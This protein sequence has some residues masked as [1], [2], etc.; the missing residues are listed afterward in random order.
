MF[1]ILGFPRL[2]STLGWP[3]ETEDLKYWYPTSVLITGYDIIF[4][5]VAR[6]I[7]SG[8]EQMNEEPFKYVFIHGLVR[9]S[10]GRKMSKSLGN[11]IDPLDALRFTL[12]TGNSP[13]N[14]M[15]FYTERVESSRNFAN[16]LWNAARFVM[17]NLSID[18]ISLPENP[19]LEDKWILSK[20]NT[21]VQEVTENLEKFEVGVAVAKLYDFIWDV[22]CDWYIELVKPRL[23]DENCDTKTD[24]QKTLAYV[25][26]GVLKLLHPFMPF[27]TEEIYCALPVSDETIVIS[28]WPQYNEN[29]NFKEEEADMTVICDAI[30]GIR[31]IRA[32]MNIPP[33][34]KSK[35]IIVTEKSSLFCSGEAF[36]KKLAYASEVIITS[37]KQEINAV[38]VIVE[39]A[40]LMLPTDELIDKEKEIVRLTK[41]KENLEGE[42][43]RSKGKLSN[44]GFLDKA[45]QKLIEEEK[46][47]Y[48]KYK[49][50]LSK[51]S[52]SLNGMK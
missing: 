27:I 10:E 25:L 39:G 33:S 12:A 7:F 28:Q 46:A 44:Q 4:F 43:K 26:S 47:K 14:D 6:M 24:A 40:E 20:Y 29:L 36:L 3:D 34:K 2:F 48:E 38:S 45:P 49:D 37:E 11:G 32:E 9:D 35:L 42:I 1:L 15:R 17:M 51:V 22:Y 13:G 41:E 50:M 31:N 8:M 30:R 19:Q 52:E 21:L 5:W 18:E 23:Y 16:K